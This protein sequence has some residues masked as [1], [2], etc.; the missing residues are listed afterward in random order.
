LIVAK[1]DVMTQW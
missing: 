1:V